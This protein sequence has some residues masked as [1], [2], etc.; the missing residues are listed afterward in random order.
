M[1]QHIGTLLVSTTIVHKFLNSG[2][3]SAKTGEQ[4]VAI[5][6][7]PHS[8][9]LKWS[10]GSR[11]L[12]SLCTA[13]R[14]SDSRN[15]LEPSRCQMPTHVLVQKSA[16]Y[17]LLWLW[18]LMLN[19]WR[20]VI[21]G[22]QQRLTKQLMF[23]KSKYSMFVWLSPHLRELLMQQ[24]DNPFSKCNKLNNKVCY[25]FNTI[26]TTM[27]KISHLFQKKMSE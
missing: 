10:N 19:N 14:Q 7:V 26:L 12:D 11:F 5:W 1:W 20:H 4:L 15:F 21:S 17:H 2:Y 24:F 13:I 27:G 9:Q 18:T 6:F 16:I 22:K 3:L 25:M 8:S 23:H